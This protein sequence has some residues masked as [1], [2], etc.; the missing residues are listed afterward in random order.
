MASFVSGE[1]KIMRMR[2]CHWLEGEI[3]PTFNRP[4]VWQDGWESTEALGKGPVCAHLRTLPW[5]A[6]LGTRGCVLKTERWRGGPGGSLRCLDPFQNFGC[7]SLKVG[8]ADGALRHR[9]GVWH[10]LAKGWGREES[11]DIA[12]SAHRT[13][14]RG[15]RKPAEGGWVDIAWGIE[16]QVGLTA[17][18]AP[19][20][21]LELVA[22]PKGQRGLWVWPGLRSQ[23]LLKGK[24]W[25][26]SA[27]IWISLWPWKNLVGSTQIISTQSWL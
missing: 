13:F 20:C 3:S 17:G 15:R 12:S 24:P 25:F 5:G 19:Q 1:G 4:V 11:G 6:S 22:G 7:G 23:S 14:T 21:P 8:R 26:Y 27:N 18:R 16:S 9:P 10:E 2:M